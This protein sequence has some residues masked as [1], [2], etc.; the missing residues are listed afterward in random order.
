[1]KLGVIGFGNMASSIIIGNK[2]KFTENNLNLFIL[3]KFMEI[4]AD[5]E[6]KYNKVKSNIEVVKQSDIILLGVKPQNLE[7]ILNE[8]ASYLDNKVIISILAGIEQKYLET[9]LISSKIIRVF[10]NLACK[11]KKSTT[12]INSENKLN[13]EEYNFVKDLFKNV[14]EIILMKEDLF[15]VAGSLSSCTPAYLAI[16]VEALADAAVLKGLPRK[17][18]YSIAIDTLIGSLQYLK[19]TKILPA[20]LKDRVCSPAGTT[21]EGIKALERNNFRNTTMEAIIASTDKTLQMKK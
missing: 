6:L 17:D 13:E 2:D 7:E 3:D 5:K 21:I 20:E 19:E 4:E 1:M 10:P 15:P 16:F 8:I 12:L 14:G 9:R 18:S 11:V